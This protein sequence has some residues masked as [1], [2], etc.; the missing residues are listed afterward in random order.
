M[1]K[2]FWNLFLRG[3]CIGGADI[4]PGVSGGT[5][6]FI[7]GIYEELVDSIRT[8][9]TKELWKNLLLLRLRPLLHIVNWQFLLPVALGVVLMALSFA[10]ILEYLMKTHPVLLWSFFFGLIL[11]S[12]HVVS[13]RIRRWT[14][15]RLVTLLC[16]AGIA[17]LFVGILPMETPETWWFLTLAGVLAACAGLLP[18]IS[19]AFVLVLLGKYHFALS[20]LNEGQFF[21]LL[22]LGIGAIAGLIFFSR[23]ISWLLNHYHDTTVAF[24]TGLML[25]SLRKVW[26]W[27]EGIPNPENIIPPLWINQAPNPDVLW[28]VALI[29]IGCVVVFLLEWWGYRKHT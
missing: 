7:L 19:G 14:H 6:A 16:G 9:G 4:I 29:V 22:P 20:S 12:L 18:G 8:F 17:Y 21:N 23:I 13:R 5:M 2:R 28:G 1:T 26:P 11:A 25:G 24:L 3:M 15:K 10:K 27:K